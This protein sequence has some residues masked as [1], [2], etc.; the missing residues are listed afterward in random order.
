MIEYSDTDASN[1]IQHTVNALQNYYSGRIHIRAGKYVFKNPITLPNDIHLTISGEGMHNTILRFE[2]N[3]SYPSAAISYISD[4]FY[5]D[6]PFTISGEALSGLGLSAYLEIKDLT[7]WVKD[8]NLHGLWIQK[9]PRLVL[10][11]IRI[12][13]LYETSLPPWNPSTDGI[14]IPL[15]ISNDFYVL[16][17]VIVSGFTVGI[18]IFADHTLLNMIEVGLTQVAI[19]IGGN[20]IVMIR[21]HVYRVGSLAYYFVYSGSYITVIE[22]RAESGY[23]TA[24]VV[25]IE[26]GSTPYVDIFG[27]TYS[28]DFAKLITNPVP[29]VRFY[30]HR[31]QNS[32]VATISAGSTRVTVNHGLISTP[33]KFQITPLG[34][35]PGKL[36]V[37][38]ITNTSFDIV[39][40]TAP[41]SNLKVSWYAE[42]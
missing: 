14:Y 29:T 37:E 40:D 10:R 20:G 26:S 35:P 16:D 32:G 15:S 23:G 36:W 25:S 24:T 33:T 4:K 27:L 2:T 38:N 7:I 9:I 12:K 19:K 6:N 31:W 3:A 39:T 22:P 17:H 28:G 30:G 41:A 34:Q 5:Q 21:P 1:V 18:E 42:V 11:N 13:G 8:P